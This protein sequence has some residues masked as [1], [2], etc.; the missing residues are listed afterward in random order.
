ML[1]KLLLLTASFDTSV[2]TP[3]QSSQ[4]LALISLRR[5]T[6]SAKPTV[7]PDERYGGGD[8]QDEILD[9]GNFI[10][11]V[12]LLVSDQSVEI[13]EIDAWVAAKLGGGPDGA[14]ICVVV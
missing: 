1:T 7:L 12:D 3:P 2:T 9:L 8:V 6:G 14:L 5:I 11:V 13:N 10:L 4:A